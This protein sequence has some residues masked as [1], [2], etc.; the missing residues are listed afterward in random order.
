MPKLTKMTIALLAALT[1]SIN[2]QSYAAET[3]KT[4]QDINLHSTWISTLISNILLFY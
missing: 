2:H 3:K 1:A 4:P